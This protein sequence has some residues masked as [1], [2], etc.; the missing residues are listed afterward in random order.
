MNPGFPNITGPALNRARRHLPPLPPTPASP[1][2]PIGKAQL[3]AAANPPPPPLPYDP[4]KPELDI[5][6]EPHNIPPPIPPPI[7]EWIRLQ[8]QRQQLQ[9][10]LQQQQQQ[11]QQQQQQQQQPEQQ[12]EQ[13]NLLPQEAMDTPLA[14]PLFTGDPSQDATLWWSTFEHYT[15][16][17][18]LQDAQA[19]SLFPLL[20]RDT[21]AAWYPTLAQGQTDTLAHL[22]DAFQAAFKSN[23]STKWSKERALYKLEQQPSQTV[24]QYITSVRSAAQGLDLTDDQ[25]I[26]LIIG[27]LHPNI[28]T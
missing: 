15:T 11:L 9:Q 13:L 22:K 24:L 20:L 17:K 1:R 21:A 27:G 6:A 2:L 26:R 28:R 10:Q 23:N 18:S 7:D 5:P 14:P 12:Q 16:Y 19:R 25:M 4:D 8:Q 3:P